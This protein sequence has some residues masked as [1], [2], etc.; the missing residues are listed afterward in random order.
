MERLFEE[1]VWREEILKRAT[2]TAALF[3]YFNLDVFSIAVAMECYLNRITL[4]SYC[5]SFL[6]GKLCDGWG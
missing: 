1:T 4:Q 2:V 5:I 3:Q 6:L